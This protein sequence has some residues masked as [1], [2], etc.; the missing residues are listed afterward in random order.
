M[1]DYIVDSDLEYAYHEQVSTNW[2]IL[3]MF[4]INLDIV[5]PYYL[6]RANMTKVGSFSSELIFIIVRLFSTIIHMFV[7]LFRNDKLEKQNSRY[8]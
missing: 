8:Q 6:Y 2:I 5:I 4:Y 3:S 7:C 1:I